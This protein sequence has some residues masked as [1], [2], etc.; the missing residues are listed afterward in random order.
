M[1]S[2]PGGG[3]LLD[4]GSVQLGLVGGGLDADHVVHLYS[5]LVAAGRR[6]VRCSMG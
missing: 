2:G 3:A 1:F 6:P 4:G 5:P